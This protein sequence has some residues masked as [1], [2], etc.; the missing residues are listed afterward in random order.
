DGEPAAYSLAAGVSLDHDV[1]DGDAA[2]MHGPLLAPGV[3]AGEAERRDAVEP[4]RLSVALAFGQH[5]V[6]GGAGV[7]EPVEAVQARLGARLPAEAIGPVD[8]EA[9][10]PGELAA[11]LRKIGKADGGRLVVGSV[12]ETEAGEEGNWELLRLRVLR[13]RQ[14]DRSSVRM[15]WGSRAPPS[16]RPRV[17]RLACTAGAATVSGEQVGDGEA[18]HLHDHVKRAARE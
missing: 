14:A 1:D 18:D 12:S 7:G 15:A 5:D 8:R 2:Q 4:E 6:P 17:A 10:A 9:E 3:R 16:P 11:V 13:E